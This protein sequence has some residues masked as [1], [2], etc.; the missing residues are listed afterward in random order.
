M[1]LPVWAV[2]IIALIV[3][4]VLACLAIWYINKRKSARLRSLLVQYPDGETGENRKRNINEVD[5]DDY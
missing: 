5:L 4:A 1:G 2:I 3:M